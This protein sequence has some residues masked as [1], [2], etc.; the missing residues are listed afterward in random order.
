M[1]QEIKNIAQDRGITRICH[2][3]PSR[4]LLHIAA[5]KQGILAT[6]HLHADERSILNP[7]DLLRLD[8]HKGYINCTIEYPNAWYFETARQGDILFR[9]WVVLLIKPDYLWLEGTKFSAVNAAKGYGMYIAEGPVAFQNLFC[10]KPDGSKRCRSNRHLSCC[11]TDQ[12]AEVLIPDVV[13]IQ[14]IIGVGVSCEAQAKAERSRLKLSGVNPNDFV[15][16]ITPAFY[17]KNSLSNA[18]RTG[19][20]PAEQL[21]RSQ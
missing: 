21:Y 16:Y 6:K 5:G 20:R 9:D 12:Q 18:I 10:E 13:P 17:E 15:F 2:F 7:T 19:I 11:P 8:N 14:D 3:T 1:T 4:N